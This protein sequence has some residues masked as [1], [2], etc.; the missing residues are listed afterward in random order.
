MGL[1]SPHYALPCLG[2]LGA[3]SEQLRAAGA[4][5]FQVHGAPVGGLSRYPTEGQQGCRCCSWEE[6]AE[7]A[8][9]P[10]SS[11]ASCYLL[12]HQTQ[13]ELTPRD[14]AVAANLI[15]TLMPAAPAWAA[16]LQHMLDS[17]AKAEVEALDSSGEG[18]RCCACDRCGTS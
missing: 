5:M 11:C 14:R 15:A 17:G 9:T 8:A 18:P 4:G 1:E 7:G 2:W 3:R 13:Q 12:F 6:D 16:E 10:A